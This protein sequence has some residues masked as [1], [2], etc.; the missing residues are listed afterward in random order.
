VVRDAEALTLIED[1]GAGGESPQKNWLKRRYCSSLR[2]GPA[3]P[4]KSRTA[5][6]ATMPF[7]GSE[8]WL[9]SRLNEASA[10]ISPQQLV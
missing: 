3:T 8:L 1:R 2:G 7:S 5:W 4:A 9:H 10:R 6:I